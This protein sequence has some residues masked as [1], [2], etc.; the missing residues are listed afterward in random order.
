MQRHMIGA[1]P[2]RRVLMIVAALELTALAAVAQPSPG[3]PALETKLSLD[4]KIKIAEIITEAETRPLRDV[5]FSLSIDSVVPPEIELR[6]LP[7]NAEAVTPQVHGLNYLVVDEL[8]G[9]VEPQ[10]R[11]IVA[12]LQRWRRQGG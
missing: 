2:M 3:P 4:Q 12:V 11:K 5:K 8:I 7:A 6:A 9:L 1:R 10:S